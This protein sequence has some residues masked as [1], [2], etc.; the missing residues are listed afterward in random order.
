MFE[1]PFDQRATRCAR[2]RLPAAERSR[3]GDGEGFHRAHQARSPT[4]RRAF[5]PYTDLQYLTE[6]VEQLGFLTDQR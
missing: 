4:C 6:D 5:R 2:T 1:E 3:T